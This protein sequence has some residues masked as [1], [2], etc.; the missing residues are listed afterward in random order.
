MT[1]TAQPSP[2]VASSPPGLDAPTENPK[3]PQTTTPT[4]LNLAENLATVSVN[5]SPRKGTG[6]SSQSTNAS[7]QHSPASPYSRPESPMAEMP[8]RSAFGSG[9]VSEIAAEDGGVAPLKGSSAEISVEAALDAE[10]ENAE[11]G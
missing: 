5:S 4:I 6:M 7:V 3:S 11:A 8:L 10:G 1:G 2:Y 9:S